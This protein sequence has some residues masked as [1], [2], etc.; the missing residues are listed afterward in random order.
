M[1][2]TDIEAGRALVRIQAKNEMSRGVA[3]AKQELR[4]IGMA[5]STLGLTL[6]KASAAML[7]PLGIAATRFAKFDSEMRE[8]RSQANPTA[9]QLERIEKAAM[10]LSRS[11]K[12]NPGDIAST[13]TELL[14][15]GMDVETV[16]GGA[17]E[18]AVRFAKVGKL[19]VDKAATVMT[20]GMNVFGETADRTVNI[21]SAGADA[22]SISIEDMALS[23]S[24]ASAVAGL[25][26]QNL[27]DTA[28]AI[29][30]LGKSGVKGS[31]AGTSLKTMFLRL[32]AP[33][34]KAAETMAKYKL[35]VRDAAGEMLPMRQI[36]GELQKKLGGLGSA[37]RDQAMRQIFGTDAIRAGVILMK[38]GVD[39]WDEMAAAMNNAQT[40]AQKYETQMG[41]IAGVWAAM[42]A[43][44]DRLAIRLGGALEGDLQ[45]V[46]D[47]ITKI[48]DLSA[49]WVEQNQGTIVSLAKFAVGL[50][51]V[52]VALMAVGGSVGAM[53]TLAAL[54]SPLGIVVGLVA[55]L[56]AGAL[57]L[58]VAASGPLALAD[59]L[60]KLREAGD[61][62]RATDLALFERLR[63]LADQQNLTAHEMNEAARIADELEQKYGNLGV[64]I[65]RVTGDVNANADAFE[66]LAGV[67]RD[68]AIDQ[69][70]KEIGEQEANVKKLRGAL[71][72]ETTGDKSVWG[73]DGSLLGWL[74]GG[75]DE[76][77][78]LR[79]N[80]QLGKA[81]AE[82]QE[83]IARLDRLKNERSGK[84]A[85][86]A[87]RDAGLNPAG[88]PA[89]NSTDLT[90]DAK[91]GVSGGKPK[92]KHQIAAEEAARAAAVEE[93]ATKEIEAAK[94]RLEQ[95][96]EEL[97]GRRR[98]RHEQ[99]IHEI[100]ETAKERR[101]LLE[102]AGASALQL[103]AADLEAAAA[104]DKV[105]KEQKAEAQND[106]D[107]IAMERDAQER[108]AQARIRTL[109]IDADKTLTD[110]QKELAKLEV[111]R[112]QA[113]RKAFEEGSN[114]DLVNQEYD[115]KRAAMEADASGSQDRVQGTYSAAAAS[116][117]GDRPE[118][119]AAERRISTIL[120]NMK[121]VM[122]KIK[123]WLDKNG[124]AT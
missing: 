25:A 111:E 93:E 14:K 28:E 33:V 63:Q 102:E 114:P 95:L 37:E 109:E 35:E 96:E 82:M 17:G 61:K 59:A 1:A 62:Q 23:M 21:I 32:M 119:T 70:A 104:L 47:W 40:V 107:K 19:E 34:D 83:N 46:G 99:E 12:R 88:L 27:F 5:A 69:L 116:V 15:A 92:G 42:V 106:A 18:A 10:G 115:L 29:A 73:T 58:G 71:A 110:K 124:G 80:S 30:L 86:Q 8:L 105:R 74:I 44:A 38:A 117:M 51:G 2:R 97:A 90:G 57:Y 56:G 53:T 79:V 55:A 77:E 78:V 66:R 123:G 50:G 13:F 67:M 36:I 100:Q 39:G 41:G 84:S 75:G 20:D 54:I 31:D 87:M 103:L 48:V 98:S 89:S 43:G 81:I 101:K 65:D 49:D 64:S 91:G 60:E 16:L 122:D 68:Q 4:E 118:I 26:N 3:G 85:D 22:S 72:N 11:L 9:A 94:K 45:S 52:G 24:M 7:I 112:E 113:M 121:T 120:N 108:D 6:A 76:K